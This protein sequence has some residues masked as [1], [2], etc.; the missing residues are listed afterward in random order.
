[1]AHQLNFAI[2]QL[3]EKCFISIYNADSRPHPKTIK[4][5]WQQL[6]KHRLAKIFQQ[7]AAFIKNYPDLVKRSL[8][9]RLFLQSLATLQTRWTFTH[10]LPRILRQSQS[11]SD[12]IRKYSNA[13]VVGHGLFI[14]S[15][16]L[17]DVGGFPENSITE[18]LFLGF[19][20]RASGQTIYPLPLLELGDSPETVK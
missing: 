8:I 20:L 16:C 14:K 1:M 18:D 15:E 3:P 6:Q 12:L 2:K 19:L 10:E 5:F 9:R 11:T 7:S 4:V 17:K 13:H